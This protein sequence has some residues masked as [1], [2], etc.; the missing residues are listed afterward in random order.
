MSKHYNIKVPEKWYEH[1]LVEVTNGKDVTIRECRG[2]L[3]AH[4]VFANYVVG[5]YWDYST[6]VVST[7]LSKLAIT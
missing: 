3:E 2:K 6:G 5:T 7:S 1:H 4:Y